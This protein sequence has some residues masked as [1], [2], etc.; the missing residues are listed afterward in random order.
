MT[1]EQLIAQ[2]RIDS[3]DKLEPYLFSDE[4]II[5]WLNEAQDEACIRSL[6]LKDWETESV[7]VIPVAANA[8]THTLHPSIINITWAEFTVTGGTESVVLW[9]TDEYELDRKRPDWRKASEEPRDYIHNDTTLRFGCVPPEGMLKLEVNRLPLY[10][11]AGDSDSP[12]IA[13]IHH[14]K[15]V[16]WALFRAFSIPDSE[17]LD[18]NRAAAADA[19]F[20]Q[21]FGQRVDATARRNSESTRAHHNIVSWMG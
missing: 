14:R 17:T 13:S 3:E 4:S 21:A 15:L 20:T 7:C 18:P 8:T 16:Y 11:M 12:E 2:F 6:L 9:Q 5:Q 1:L 10:P 19:E